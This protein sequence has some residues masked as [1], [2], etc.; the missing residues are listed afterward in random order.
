M[1]K[2][3]DIR[4]RILLYIIQSLLLPTNDSERDFLLLNENRKKIIDMV[5]ENPGVSVTDIKLKLNLANGV[6]SYHLNILIKGGH[7]K[8]EKEGIYTRIW[9]SEM[10]REKLKKRIASHEKILSILTKNPYLTQK[11]I[12]EQTTLPQPTVS[13]CLRR[14][15]SEGI[16]ISSMA[17][18]NDN[19]HKIKF[20]IVNID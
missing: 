10:K 20:L 6:L 13:R 2:G 5:L 11:E 1:R 3:T 16:I 14:L 8:T 9:P 19:K 4:S 12:I 7:L 15:E 18:E 17:K